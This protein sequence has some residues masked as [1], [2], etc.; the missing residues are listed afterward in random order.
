MGIFSRKKA[1]PAFAPPELP[2]AAVPGQST[3][4]L[5]RQETLQSQTGEPAYIPPPQVTFLGRRVSEAVP[6][7]PYVHG[8]R[9]VLPG[10]AP[11]FSAHSTANPSLPR[12][13]ET[14]FEGHDLTM[15]NVFNLPLTVD[16]A[17]SDEEVLEPATMSAVAQGKQPYKMEAKLG[18]F[19]AAGED[20]DEPSAS[21]S[22]SKGKKKSKKHH[23][24]PSSSKK[25]RR[26]RH[27]R[28]SE[29]IQAAEFESDEDEP[30][31]RRRLGQKILSPVA[32]SL[33]S[34]DSINSPP[35]QNAP[36]LLDA[37]VADVML[38]NSAPRA[39]PVGDGF[40]ALDVMADHIF[41]LGVTKKKWFKPP[42]AGKNN[43]FATGVSIRAK[44]GLYRT[45]PV[46][47]PALDPFSEAITRLN[48]EVSL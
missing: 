12:F 47:C 14:D 19:D 30:V 2:M 6:N 23:G 44:T 17:D 42:R 40:D 27:S 18:W 11:S 48:P 10:R 15:A 34:M 4:S 3:A 5:H 45:F 25:K 22:K 29:E 39:V 33:N 46:G 13:G 28:P 38:L 21:K 26:H 31:Y 36:G 16:L 7:S 32:G 41:R 37:N 9:Q 20:E 35:E 8:H 1:Q 43:D 24:D